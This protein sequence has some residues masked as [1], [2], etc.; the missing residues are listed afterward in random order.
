MKFTINASPSQFGSSKRFVPRPPSFFIARAWPFS[1]ARAV[2]AERLERMLSRIGNAHVVVVGDACLDAN[3]YGCAEAVAKEAPVLA[4][5]AS[6][7]V[8]APGQATNV[9]VNAAALGARVSFL[10]VVGP[11]EHGARL[12][13]LLRAFKVDAAGLVVEAGRTTTYKVKFVAREAQR[14]RQHLFHAY[15]QE[16]RPPSSGVRKELRRSAAEAL[17]DADALVL[18]DYGN[19]TLTPGFSKWLIDESGRRGAVSV[20]NARGDLTKFRG[21]TAAVANMEELISLSGRGAADNLS[22]AMASAATKLRARH[23]VVTAGSEGMFVWPVRGRAR[24]LVPA[25]RDVVDVTGAGDTV[26]AALAAAMAAG[27][28]LAAAAALANLAAAAV[29]ARE[30]TSVAA[31]EEL[32]LFV[33]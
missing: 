29:V 26:T 15:W 8:F 24:R 14:H 21:T 33:T 19:R 7:P 23:M 6:E 9:A 22:A 32:R 4:L 28:G 13:E 16:R 25:A 31:P 10:G 20:A 1:Y 17:A 5:E 3:V 27:A 30:G 2:K 18:S 12:L 11:D